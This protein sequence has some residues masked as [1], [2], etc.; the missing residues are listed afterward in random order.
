VLKCCQAIE[1]YGLY[2]Q[3]VYRV[4]GMTSKVAALKAKLDRDLDAVD[5]D[6]SEWAEDINNVTSVLKMWLR[7]LPDPLLTNTLHQGFIDAAKIE[8]D[9]LRHIRLHERVNEL[10]DPNYSTLKFLMGHLHRIS[11]QSADNSMSTSNLAIVFG[12]TLFGQHAMMNGQGGM[13]DA[14]YQNQAIETILNHYVDI[15]I[16]ETD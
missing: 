6:Q 4:N 8:N 14:T 1:K 13:V 2:S 15:F 11:Q 5:L 9:R 7:E 10:P 3:G 12:P 16:D